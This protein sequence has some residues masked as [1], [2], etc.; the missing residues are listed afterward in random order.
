MIKAWMIVLSLT[1]LVGSG[2]SDCD[3]KANSRTSDYKAKVCVDTATKRR[4]IQAPCDHKEAGFR[5]MYFPGDKII[6]KVG[7]KIPSGGGYT[8]P[9]VPFIVRIPDNEA[10]TT[11]QAVGTR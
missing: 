4:A 8:Q 5:W 6:P 11:A 2:A 7:A 9:D 10:D 1:A 3:R